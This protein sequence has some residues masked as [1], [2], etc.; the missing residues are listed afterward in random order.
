[1]SIP[2]RFL[3]ELRSRL[4]LSDIIGRTVR[5]TRAGREF[6]GC[7]PFHNEKTPS[8]TV[9][10]DKQFYHCFGC[11]AHGDVIGF[12]MEA[13]NYS[14]IE[15]LEMLAG[16]AGMQVPQQSP[17]QIAQAKEEKSLYSLMDDATRWMED[18]L[19]LPANKD[20]YRY[21]LERGN[22]DELLRNFRV[23]YAPH[24]GQAIRKAMQA[25]DYTDSQMID[26]GVLRAGKAGR[27]PYAFFRERIMFPV[28]DRRGRVVA[29][30]GRTLP[31]HLLA[32]NSGD[33][34]PAKYMNSSDT[35]LFHK[36]SM[37]YGEP[38]ARQAALDGQPLIVVEGYI[39]VMASF[40]ADYRGALAPMGTAL[41]E[42]QIMAIWRM[43]PE[44]DKSPIL[45]FDGDN[46][47][48][49]AASRACE[50][51][52]PLLKANHSARF[53]F[54]PD[55]QDPDSLVNSGGKRA[56]ASIIQSAMPLVDFLWQHHTLG[57]NFSTPEAQ[58][59]LSKTLED[60]VLRIAERDVQHYYRQALRAKIRENFGV[61]Y[62][63]SSYG[64]NKNYH[65]SVQQ[66]DATPIRKPSFSRRLLTEQVLIAGLIN[67][68]ALFDMFEE[69]IGRL[70][71]Q[72]ERLDQLRQ[73]ALALLLSNSDSTSEELLNHLKN[74]GFNPDLKGLLS[75]SVYT[76]AHFIRPSNDIE[77]VEKGWQNA[78][79]LLNQENDIRKN[80]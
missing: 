21:I 18:Q 35:T 11:G 72:E 30:G 70:N 6:K 13:N 23:G 27:E 48:R 28:M 74:K 4:T 20:A 79:A 73:S 46:A 66:Q 36:G 38:H 80:G 12:T 52:L 16:E 1:M 19:R 42:E 69:E 37:L 24:D 15:A 78:L 39:D 2:P 31:D 43:I 76:H 54:L 7:C 26:C 29:F 53:A 9:N 71:I 63:K 57:K 25:L 10:D 8:F 67:H 40:K 51:L 17:Q 49:R 75:E 64:A 3:D 32:P 56:F 34:T 14:F 59:G 44:G 77:V 61:K 58:A 5:L 55:G 60:E 68:P 47:G 41:T 22:D 50:R 65:K 45:C 33:Y 62:N